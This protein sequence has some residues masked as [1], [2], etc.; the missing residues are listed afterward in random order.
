MNVPQLL[1]ALRLGPDVE[2]VVARQP[3]RSTFNF[4][5]LPRNI[6]LQHLQR[7]RELRSFRLGD[8]QMNVLGHDY[9][10]GDVEAIPFS[11]LF[12]ILLEE[13]P[14]A[15]RA[16]ARLAPIGTKSEKVQTARFLKSLETPWHGFNRKPERGRYIVSAEIIHALFRE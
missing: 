10:S 15:R 8:Q 4:A 3:K 1:N 9:I 2:V 7:N 14:S 13:I 16:Q 5:Q 12:Q 6:L 11:R